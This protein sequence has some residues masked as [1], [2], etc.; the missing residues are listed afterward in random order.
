MAPTRGPLIGTPSPARSQLRA[1]CA[2][3]ESESLLTKPPWANRW[4]LVGVTMPMLLHMCV[5]YLPQLATIFQ[6][7]TLRPF[8]GPAAAA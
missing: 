8:A 5:L 2:V 7:R 6:A 3:S 4:L 1:M